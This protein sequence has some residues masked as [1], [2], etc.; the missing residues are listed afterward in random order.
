MVGNRNRW[1]VGSAMVVIVAAAAACADGSPLTPVQSAA[2]AKAPELG[3]CDNLQADAGTKLAYRTYAHGTQ[4]YRWNGTGWAF[5]APDAQLFADAGF[6]GRVGDHYAGPTWRSNS[7]STV[8]AAVVDRCTPDASA[9]PWLILG[10][11]SSE[12]PGVF[13]GITQIQRLS[14]TGGLAPAEPGTTVGEEREVPYTAEYFFYR[15]K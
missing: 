1:I 5:V 2:F 14:T 10:A 9:I 7:G 15:A 12:G 8:V 6:H 3:A 11:T 4:V 13:K